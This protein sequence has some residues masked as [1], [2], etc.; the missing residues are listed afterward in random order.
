MIDDFAEFVSPRQVSQVKLEDLHDYMD[1]YTEEQKGATVNRKMAT[2]KS[3]LTFCF[4]TGMIPFDVGRALRMPRFPSQLAE[5]ILPAADVKRMIAKEP[6]PRNRVLLRMLYMTAMRASEA[7]GLRWRD[8]QQRG[9]AAGQ[10]TVWGK[11]GKT[12]A[13]HLQAAAWRE[14]LSI[15]PER[16]GPDEHVFVSDEGRP[17]HR[18]TITNLVSKAAKRAGIEAKVSA[19]WMRHAH[20]SHSIDNG[21]PLTLVR[22]TLGHVSLQT[23]SAYIHARPN[24]SS[25]KYLR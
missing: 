5:K 4:K 7:A 6:S 24:E 14:L 10:I 22:E 15:R 17:L 18:V 8:V 21:A 16:P 9:P 1:R 13:V 23:T 2:I 19:H 11:G 20:A 12:R 3:L 25:G